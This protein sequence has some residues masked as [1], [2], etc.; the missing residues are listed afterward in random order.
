MPTASIHPDK[1][2]MAVY[3]AQSRGLIRCPHG[4]S[5]TFPPGRNVTERSWASYPW[6]RRPGLQADPNA[7]PKPTWQWITD[8]VRKWELEEESGLSN[9]LEMT[10]SD[11]EA[12]AAPASLGIAREEYLGKLR[13]ECRKKSPPSTAQRTRKTSYLFECAMGPTRRKTPNG[14][15]CG[16]DTPKSRRGPWA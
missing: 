8:M 2:T 1:I 3:D 10:L 7:S 6:N 13:R 16:R 9:L 15:G 12:A 14:T 11:A 4:D 5:L